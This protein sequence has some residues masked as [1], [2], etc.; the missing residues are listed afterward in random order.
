M[1]NLTHSQRSANWN[2]NEAHF[3]IGDEKTF[4]IN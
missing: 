3:H 1:S 4:R 2:N